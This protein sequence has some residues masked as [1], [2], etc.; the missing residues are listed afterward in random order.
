MSFPS[1]RYRPGMIACMARDITARQRTE[2]ELRAHAHGL[3]AT[4]RELTLSMTIMEMSHKQDSSVLDLLEKIPMLLPHFL[5]HSEIACA[6]PDHRA[7]R[8]QV[9]AV[10][11]NGLEAGESDPAFRR[12]RR[13]P[14]CLLYGRAAP[15]LTSGP[16]TNEGTTL[17]P[18]RRR[19]DR[20]HSRAQRHP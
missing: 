13:Q 14:C 5:S 12:E 19:A 16:F 18:Q 1:V 3:D 17:A 6:R 8:I 9:G 10:S 20:W 11:R 15:Q 4:V 7:D 2:D